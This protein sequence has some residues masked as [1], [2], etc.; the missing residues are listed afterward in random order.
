M[1][2]RPERTGSNLSGKGNRF[3]TRF[4]STPLVAALDSLLQDSEG[5]AVRNLA[6]SSWPLLAALIHCL[7]PDAPILLVTAGAKLQESVCQ[8]LRTWLNWLRQRPGATGAE[9]PDPYLPFSFPTHERSGQDPMDSLESVGERLE[10]MLNLSDSGNRTPPIVAD[11][12][13]LLQKTFSPESLQESVRTLRVGQTLDPRELI[14]WLQTMAY[15][16]EAQVTQKGEMAQRGGIVDVF[17]VTDSWPLR[18]EFFGNE[19]D[20]IREFDPLTQLSR[21]K[22]TSVTISPGDESG[23]LHGNSDWN[24]KKRSRQ[25]LVS[26]VRHLPRNAILIV[27]NPEEVEEQAAQHGR[28]AVGE[29]DRYE[30]WPELL[31]YAGSSGIRTLNWIGETG[32]PSGRIPVFEGLN[33]AGSLVSGNASQPAIERIRQLFFESLRRWL[34]SGYRV[35]VFCNNQGERDRFSEIWAESGCSADSCEGE[36]K[37]QIGILGGGFLVASARWAV[38]TDAEIF[39]RYRTQRTWRLK[40]GRAKA[41]GSAMEI[42]YTDL[43]PGDYIVHLQHGIGR[44]VGLKRLD[45]DREDPASAAR[46]IECL[47]IEFGTRKPTDSPPRLYVNVTEAHLVSKYIGDGKASPPLSVLGGKKW[48]KAKAQANEAVIDLAGEMLSIQA[49]REAK[50]GHAYATDTHWQ[51]EFESSFMFE[52]T[53]DQLVSIES[54]KQDMESSRPMDRLICGD[55]GFGKT[56]V[57]IRAA[58]KAVMGSKQVAVLVPTTILAQQHYQT[59]S[60]RMRDYPIRIEL[61]SS[62]RKASQLRKVVQAMGDGSVD[63]VVG[64]HRLIQKDIRF[65]DL[66]LVIIDEEQ[67]FGVAHKEKFKRL[68]SLVDVL[69]LSATPIPRTLHMALIGARDMSTIET[70]PHDRL[71]VETIVTPY[72]EGVIRQ[73]I[74]REL[75][76]EGQVYFLHNRVNS[77]EKVADKIRQMAPEAH[78]VVGH[79]QMEAGELEATMIAFVEGKADILVATTIIESGLDIP[80][81]NTII[82]DRADRFGLS[83]LYQLR[84]RVGRYKRQAYAYLLIPR[85]AGMMSDACRRIEAMKRYARLGSGFKIA[86][87]DLEIRGAGNMLGSQQS[88]HITAVG[89]ELYCQLLK[90]SI[91][92]MQGRPVKKRNTVAVSLDFLSSN[93]AHDPQNQARTADAA[94]IPYDYIGEEK[95]RLEM[96]RKVAQA[97]EPQLLEQLE[98]ELLD[99]FGPLPQAVQLLLK[100][101]E[102][103]QSAGDGNITSV[104]TAKDKVMLT[105]NGDYLMPNGRFPRLRKNRPAARLEELRRI[106]KKFSAPKPSPIVAP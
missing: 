5:V 33:D 97:N 99:R 3:E 46:G 102:I 37:V 18:L 60:E 44:F 85:H 100:V 83:D 45:Q 90:Q 6:P 56:E 95:L 32:E 59:F 79:G 76:R 28:L 13:A 49:A 1:S 62:F 96:Y 101:A 10:V 17:P 94:Y 50:K 22:V 66:G 12:L 67:R 106:I 89:F 51:H 14:E 91:A 40:T 25:K 78:V 21:N 104:E 82:V 54:C 74:R 7:E 42:D 53:P 63:I 105:R 52:E 39:G 70:A 73:A 69:T 16:P 34:Q 43:S 15:E 4:A 64:T 47:V 48:T 11:V 57:A 27:C 41:V 9:E 58:F 93:P 84:G 8:D 88:G 35:D 81:A 36:L 38:V 87:R 23:L 19:I 103:R 20:S 55:V 24:S 2:D 29:E 75:N 30:L 72:D 31:D 77:I 86:M 26:L 65:K 92:S 98:I 68:R 71:P 61:L 80:N